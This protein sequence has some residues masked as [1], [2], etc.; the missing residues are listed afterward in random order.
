ASFIPSPST[1]LMPL[2]VTFSNTSSP[3]SVDYWWT[4]GNSSTT[5][6]TV[7]A[8]TVYQMQGTYTVQLVV[9]NGVCYDTATTTIIVDMVS[10]LTIPNVFTPNGDG[11][12][13]IF[14][15]NPINI[16]DISMTIFDRWGLKMYDTT[17]TGSLTWDG[18]TKSGAPVVDG[19]YFY[20]IQAKGLD[21]KDFNFQGTV[22]IF[23]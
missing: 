8:A 18:K 12:N 3:N 13:D 1:G 15:L 6:T 17:T 5:Y 4:L 19:T 10:F 7:N 11:V 9:R 14:S 20:I 16:G 23:R 2:P 21:G 22:N